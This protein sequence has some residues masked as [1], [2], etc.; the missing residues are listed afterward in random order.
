MQKENGQKSGLKKINQFNYTHFVEPLEDKVIQDK[1]KFHSKNV[2]E[3][4]LNAYV[5]VKLVLFFKVNL[6]PA[7]SLHFIS[8]PA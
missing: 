6:L 3:K 5:S 1:I 4:Q 7:P 8:K 2:Y